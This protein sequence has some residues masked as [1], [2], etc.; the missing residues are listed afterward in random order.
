MFVWRILLLKWTIHQS[1]CLP[2][3]VY[4]RALELILRRRNLE[5]ISVPSLR[6]IMP[7][8]IVLKPLLFLVHS[9]IKNDIFNSHIDVTNRRHLVCKTFNAMI[10]LSAV[11]SYV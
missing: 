9:L 2:C 8:A 11:S 6:G 10:L 5:E 4:G 1:V 3:C 7:P